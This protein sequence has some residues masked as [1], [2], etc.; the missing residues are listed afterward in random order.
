V[1]G[2]FTVPTGWKRQSLHTSQSV[3]TTMVLVIS[4]ILMYIAICQM[5]VVRNSFNVCFLG[6]SLTD[7]RTPT[8][9]VGVHHP[10]YIMTLDY[11]IHQSSAYS[12]FLACHIATT[13]VCRLNITRIRIVIA[14][15]CC[16]TCAQYRGSI[17]NAT[18]K[19]KRVV[20][21]LN[22]A[23]SSLARIPHIVTR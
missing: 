16:Q 8:V 17:T 1:D 18:S 19:Q 9:R 3:P 7:S 4:N 21:F 13:T 15:D 11:V 23:L 20:E 2:P 22:A 14:M 5:L 10:K 12:L 6:S